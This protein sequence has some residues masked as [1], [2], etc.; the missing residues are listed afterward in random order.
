MDIT[1]LGPFGFRFKAQ[2]F[3]F[4]TEPYD[5]N[6]ALNTN[7]PE[8]DVVMLS[9]PRPGDEDALQGRVLKKL[10]RGPGEYEISGVFING[11]KTYQDNQKGSERGTNTIYRLTIEH[12]HVCTLGR[13]GHILTSDNASSLGDVDILLVP[14][15]D[16]SLNPD[17]ASEIVGVLEPKVVIPMGR[18]IEPAEPLPEPLAAFLKELGVPHT[19]HQDR[20]TVT[21]SALPPEPQVSILASRG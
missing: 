18:G 13:L 17:A 16:T 12:L 6:E 19:V 2:G 21:S 5:A 8:S 14:L 9:H 1:R 15:G 7:V 11:V 10:L 3:S 4:A 20:F